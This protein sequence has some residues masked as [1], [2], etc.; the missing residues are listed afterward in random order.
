[1]LVLHIFTFMLYRTETVMDT[2]VPSVIIHTWRERCIAVTRGWESEP[3]YWHMLTWPCMWAVC[4][5][6]YNTTVIELYSM[7]SSNSLYICTCG[8]VVCAWW[9]C[10]RSHPHGCPHPV[11]WSTPLPLLY[12]THSHQTGFHFFSISIGIFDVHLSI[13]SP[14]LGSCMGHARVILGSCMGHTSPIDGS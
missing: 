9:V 11:P 6:G 10:G 1:M 13:L 8:H 3:N 7:D 4:R 2:G 14:M 5:Q 12:I